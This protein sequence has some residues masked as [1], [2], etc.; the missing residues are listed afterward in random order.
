MKKSRLMVMVA[1]ILAAITLT[2]CAPTATGVA[3]RMKMKYGEDFK[4]VGVDTE[5]A[6]YYY[7]T[8]KMDPKEKIA[9]SYRG[10]KLSDEYAAYL[11]QDDVED[12]LKQYF[13][14]YFNDYKIYVRFHQLSSELDGNSTLEDLYEE[15]PYVRARIDLIVPE[16]EIS[17]TADMNRRMEECCKLIVPEGKTY[18]FIAYPVSDDSFKQFERVNIHDLNITKTD[19][20]SGYIYDGELTIHAELK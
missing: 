18:S 16:S 9:V 2:G 6:Q 8:A 1:G 19:T 20:W 15:I 14:Q 4:Y 3:V 17:D 11:L 10:D 7:R 12:H 13:D 5:V